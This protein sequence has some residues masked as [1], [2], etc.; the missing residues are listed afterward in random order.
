MNTIASPTMTAFNP[1]IT[2]LA[3]GRTSLAP[4]ITSLAP[5]ITSLAPGRTS[6][7]PGRT[8]LADLLADDIA[9]S[10]H[11]GW[12]RKQRMGLK[13][14][15]PGELL[16]QFFDYVH[17][18]WPH[19][20]VLS[21]EGVDVKYSE[22]ELR[23]NQL[24]RSLRQHGVNSKTSV[25]IY[26]SPSID[27]Y[28]ALLAVLKAGA[29]YVQLDPQISSEQIRH[30][31][32]DAKL[33]AII[34]D[35]ELGLRQDEV[36]MPLIKLDRGDNADAELPNDSADHDVPGIGGDICYIIYAASMDER[37]KGV[38]VQPRQK[39]QKLRS[40]VSQ[41]NGFGLQALTLFGRSIEGFLGAV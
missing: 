30:M 40:L 11:E 29:R 36:D 37:P 3:P 8:S 19:D 32:N 33:T 1:G 28:V 5:R 38:A 6:L 14:Q 34:T 21:I 13:L 39:L 4:R 16:H 20:T 12:K 2:S 41:Q 17:D 27:A 10:L 24:A 9:R 7:A 26:L 15:S 35:A 22:L 25:G 18:Q 31:A 23:S